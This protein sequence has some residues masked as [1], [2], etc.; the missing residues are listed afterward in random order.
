VEVDVNDN[1]TGRWDLGEWKRVTAFAAGGTLYTEEHGQVSA[2]DRATKSW[3][4][5]VEMPGWS[6]L[7]ADGNNLVFYRHGTQTLRWVPL[8][9]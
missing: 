7:G 6:L 9:Q 2:F 1:T 3:H 5:M 4:P 8:S